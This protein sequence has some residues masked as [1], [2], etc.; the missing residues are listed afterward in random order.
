MYILFMENRSYDYINDNNAKITFFC[1]IVSA[2]LLFAF[3]RTKKT[4]KSQIFIIILALSFVELTYNSHEMLKQQA[5]A[6]RTDFVGIVEDVY[7]ITKEILADDES[8]YRMAQDF[9]FNRNNPMLYGYSGLSHYSSNEKTFV[10][11]FLGNIGFRNNGN[12]AYYGKGNTLTLDSQKII[13]WS[14][15]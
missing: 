13:T 15:A 14:G 2:F 7:P 9:Q 6:H 12:W 3:S 4:I 5:Y 11:E 8:F 10:K 1:L